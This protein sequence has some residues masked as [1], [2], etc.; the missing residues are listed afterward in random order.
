[1]A[2]ERL[3]IAN[4][5]EIAIRVMRAAAELGIQT[6]AI[7][8]DD[9]AAS[10]HTRKAD[11]AIRIEG[12]GAAAYLD[13]AQVVG[14]A[15]EAGCDAVHPGYG[16]LSESADFAR[17]VEE[18]GLTFVGPTPETLS[19]FGDKTEARALAERVGVPVV[20]GVSHAVTL[21]EAR[22]FLEALPAGRPMLIK[23]VSGGG[24]RG[25]RI[26]DDPA[27]LEA[28]YER[29]Q[30][31][32]QAAFGSGEVYIEELMPRAGCVRSEGSNCEV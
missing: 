20:P 21:E 12:A 27:D 30:S 15:V 17:A 7:Y 2:I 13:A 18:G 1:M 3:L 23:A 28:A 29:C 32:A 6:V 25:M 4:R 24:G 26:V 16:F 31:E 11:E 19:L 14:V 9:A 22:T 5:G 8:P 10:L